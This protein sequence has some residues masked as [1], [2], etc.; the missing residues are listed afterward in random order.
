MRDYIDLDPVPY[1]E[2][3]QQVGTSAYDD[4]KARGECRRLIAG[5][6]HYFGDPEDANAVLRIASNP[7][8]FGCYYSVR[9]YYTDEDEASVDYAYLLEGNMPESWYELENSTHSAPVKGQPVPAGMEWM[10]K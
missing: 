5:L 8:D 4:D 6:R 3:C 7:H 1:G 10:D 9:V 2:S